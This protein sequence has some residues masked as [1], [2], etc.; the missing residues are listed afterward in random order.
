MSLTACAISMALRPWA[1]LEAVAPLAPIAPFDP[2]EAIEPIK[3]I[4]GGESE[5]GGADMDTAVGGSGS[6]V[7]SFATPVAPPPS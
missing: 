7:V 4:G 1:G 5:L 6:P 3:P 2:K